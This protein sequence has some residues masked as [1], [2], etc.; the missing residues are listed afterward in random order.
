MN[1][2]NCLSST[3]AASKRSAFTLIELLVVISIISL[4]IAILL[5]AL[6]AARE[7][8][9]N[10]KCLANLR[11]Y[12]TGL[13]SY[14]SQNKD[15]LPHPNPNSPSRPWPETVGP[16]IASN[17]TG[18]SHLKNLWLCPSDPTKQE[19]RS[20]YGYNDHLHNNVGSTKVNLR[21]EQILQL[22]TVSFGEMQDTRDQ[23]QIRISNFGVETSNGSI[24]ARHGGGTTSNL[25]TFQGDAKTVK[26][27]EL[28][29]LP[30]ND[31]GDHWLYFND[32]I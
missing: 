18:M 20:S 19:F 25:A 12:N 22:T 29:N 17:D 2:S 10:T 15:Y 30:H 3:V 11:S 1:C 26:P 16:Y 8:A 21:I 5:P 28:H 14:A 23:A 13:F 6:G 27:A 9:Q 4:L 32:R 31:R 24:S 7:A